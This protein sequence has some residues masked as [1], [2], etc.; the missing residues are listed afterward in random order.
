MC[1]QDAIMVLHITQLSFP[2]VLLFLMNDKEK[3]K[4]LKVMLTL[5][6]CQS[7]GLSIA[8]RPGD[9]AALHKKI[10]LPIAPGLLSERNA[11]H[12]GAMGI[13]HTICSKDNYSKK[14]TRSE[15]R[16]NAR[17]DYNPV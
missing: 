10:M 4:G 17:W 8:I 11:L 15:T 9:G 7:Q 5:T 1:F 16:S 12:K 2:G 3:V 13:N 14:E 6:C